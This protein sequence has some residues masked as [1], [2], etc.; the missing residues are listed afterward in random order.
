M[1]FNLCI[2][3]LL[4]LTVACKDETEADNNNGG[5]PQDAVNKLVTIDAAIR[6]QTIEGFGA[7][8]AWS[9]ETIGTLWTSER[10]GISEALFSR[11]IADGQP[12]G[13]G[14]S[15]WR[16]NLGGG[17]AE[18]GDASNINDPTRRAQS[19]LNE[20]GTAYDWTKCAG[21]RYFLDRA[22]SFG[23]EKVILFSNTPPVQYTLNG[24][25]RS[26]NRSHANLKDDCYDDFARYMADVAKHYLDLGYSVTHISPVNEPQNDW[27]GN[28][29]E[30]SGWT[31]A[32]VARL[33]R[34]LDAS[35]TK[36][37][38]TNV[39]ILLG[40]AGDY[41]HLYSSSK[42]ERSDVIRDFFSPTSQNYV[43]DLEHVK[44]LIC[45]HSYWTDGS[46][47]DMRTARITLKQSAE[48]YHV[49][50]WQTEWSMLG[51][52]YSTTEFVGYDAA[53]EMDIALY[54]SKVIHNDLT[55]AGVKSWSFWTS[56]DVPRWGHKCR[57]V[58]IALGDG[59]DEFDIQNGEGQWSAQPTLWVL[60]NYSLF[61]RPDYQRISLSL[62]ESRS[63]FGSAYISP[64]GDEV[65]TVY[66]NLSSKPVELIET[67]KN[68][69]A[70]V[71]SIV[72]YTTAE[73]SNL[74]ETVLDAD[75]S[76]VLNPKS[77]TTVVYKLK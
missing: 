47:N 4:L 24:E 77:V 33:A 64:E 51:D 41:T 23:V 60:G 12:K 45:G 43:G 27:D 25:G 8:D 44:Q 1:K 3:T 18:Q 74:Q 71:S 72:K 15:M 50:V 42:A 70:E 20:S 66:T 35:L 30:G 26:D 29:Q 61:I 36:L 75:E 69:G 14:L 55:V 68:F 59:T 73:G 11:E 16:V 56:M 17:S 49:D 62:N 63:F 37:N 28:D 67:R 65:V 53:T 2:A 52:K 39:D 48:K 34:E 22:K 10:D 32:E 57:F 54:M 46:W 13:I 31:N 19:Y 76:V 9:P 21:Q 6:Y 38:L 40:E 7:S 5:I 58:L